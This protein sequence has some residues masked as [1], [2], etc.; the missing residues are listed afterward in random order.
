MASVLP[1]SIRWVK[2]LEPNLEPDF[3]RLYKLVIKL[4]HQAK[5][6]RI[7][8][9]CGMSNSSRYCN[10]W[11]I[12]PASSRTGYKRSLIPVAQEFSQKQALSNE[13]EETSDDR[14]QSKTLQATLLTKFQTPTVDATER[15]HAGLCLRCY[16]SEPILNACR[17]I[18]RLFGNDRSFT[19]RDLLPFVLNDDGKTLVV[20]DR[21]GKTQV[22][23]DRDGTSQSIAYRFF[24]M[25]ILQTFKSNDRSS[26]SLDNWVYLQTKQN[27][28]LK[29]FLSE[30]GFKQLSDWALLNRARLKQLEQLAERD[31]HLIEVFHAVYRRDRL[32]QNQGSTRC[33]NPNTAQ[34]QE[35]ETELRSRDIP[36]ETSTLM[37]E[38]RRVALQL[39][40]YDLWS[41]REPL[42]IEDSETGDRKLRNDLPHN[43]SNEVDGEQQE[44]LAFFHGQ[45]QVALVDAIEHEMC[46]RIKT[47][48]KS[49]GYAAFAHQLIPGLHLYYSQGIS[50]KEAASILGM[51]NWAQAR[52]ILN[53]GELIGSV[54]RLTVRQVLTRMLQKAQEK[55]LTEIPPQPDY[56]ESLVE[57]IEA[58]A[59]AEIFQKAFEEI[60]AGKNRVMGSVYAQQLCIYLGKHT[61]AAQRVV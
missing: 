27:P 3:I 32:Q 24:S 20:P 38:L 7:L 35:M 15:S 25:Q 60:Q 47:L 50:L 48:K 39:R 61:K 29:N 19:Y 31:R 16:V 42:E 23:V 41:Y 13:P 51:S 11:R 37:P 14:T 34:L 30:F 36:I 5:A 54:R 56:L 22:A 9:E 44:L 8:E 58:F 52:R 55:G 17:K 21:D 59:D 28:E 49:K 4:Y 46:D 1:Q 18:D 57:Q 6:Q 26:M 40:Q 33:L 10:L 45:L 43:A 53:P 12:D 2:S